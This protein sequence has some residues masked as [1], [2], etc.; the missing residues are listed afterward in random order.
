MKVVLR[1][2]YFTARKTEAC[3]IVGW[4]TNRKGWTPGLKANRLASETVLLNAVSRSF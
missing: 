3:D 4:Y 1:L 2:I